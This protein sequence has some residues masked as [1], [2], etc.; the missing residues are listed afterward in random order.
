MYRCILTVTI[1]CYSFFAIRFCNPINPERKGFPKVINLYN[2]FFRE[3]STV[4]KILPESKSQT[5]VILRKLEKLRS[6]RS[7]FISRSLQVFYIPGAR[8]YMIS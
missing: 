4:I 5:S 2:F 6:T 1:S 7:F 3:L 8:A